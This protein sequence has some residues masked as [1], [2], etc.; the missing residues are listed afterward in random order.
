M[1]GYMVHTLHYTSGCIQTPSGQW[2]G[3]QLILSNAFFFPSGAGFIEDTFYSLVNGNSF[4]EAG[5]FGFG[6]FLVL[7][8]FA[9]TCFG[10]FVGCFFVCLFLTIMQLSMAKLRTEYHPFWFWIIGSSFYFCSKENS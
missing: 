1:N 8:L 2:L 3:K 4:T 6:N 10:F 5:W 9:L 7:C